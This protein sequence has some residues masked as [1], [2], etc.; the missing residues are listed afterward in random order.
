MRVN[1]KL[2]SQGILWLFACLAGTTAPAG[3]AP[4]SLLLVA[5]AGGANGPFLQ[6][7]D[8]SLYRPPVYRGETAPPKKQRRAKRS[9]RP[10]R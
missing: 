3:A 1:T 5:Q 9:P 10:R 7:P 2:A 6:R 4:P 8:G